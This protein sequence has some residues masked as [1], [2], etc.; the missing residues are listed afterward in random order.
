MTAHHPG[1]DASRTNPGS[2]HVALDIARGIAAFTVILWHWQHFWYGPNGNLVDFDRA[3]QPLF[4]GFRIPYELGWIGVDFFFML[5]G[6]I[7]FWRY[8]DDIRSGRVGGWRFSVLRFSRLYPLHLVTLLTVAALQGVM[9]SRL[10]HPFVYP[11]N[12]A[13]HFVL[14][15]LLAPTWGFERGWSFNAPIWSVS[16]EVLLYAGFFALARFG[17]TRW[18]QIAALVV[19]GLVIKQMGIETIGR[20]VFCFFLGGLVL[21]SVQVLRDMG[22]ARKALLAAVGVI[23]ASGATIVWNL[24]GEISQALTAGLPAE[25]RVA[26]NA[27]VTYLLFT[28]ALFPA[29]LL[30]LALGED[31]MGP[32]LRAGMSRL[33]FLGDISYSTYLIH[34][35]LQI[36]FALAVTLVNGEYSSGP[37]RM[38]AMLALYTGCLIALALLSHR[39]LEMPAQAILRAHLLPGRKLA[40]T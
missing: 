14:N 35:P 23:I 30:T 11:N 19:I 31:L 26:A 38:P 32:N 15:L 24:D 33:A 7:F 5:S 36:A 29:I 39:H 8:R 13:Y 27:L 6:F 40:P 17:L 20:G 18:W 12:D 4:D 28:V 10:G 9:V 16:V 25:L 37:F 34:F 3:A 2:R 22:S 21:M 1:G